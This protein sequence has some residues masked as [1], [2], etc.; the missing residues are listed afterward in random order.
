LFARGDARTAIAYGTH[1]V[2]AVETNLEYVVIG[3]GT[4]VAH[5]EDLVP[6]VDADSPTAR[7]GQRAAEA[8]VRYE[9]KA[10]RGNI[11]LAIGAGVILTGVAISVASGA[12]RDSPGDSSPG[13][14]IGKALFVGGVVGTIGAGFWVL[15]DVR[16]AK[17]ELDDERQSAFETYNDDL[18]KHL[19]VCADGTRIVA[20]AP[21]APAVA[22]PI[23]PAQAPS[24][25]APAFAQ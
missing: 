1:G 6:L 20:C 16:A 21:A 18:R 10:R 2:A 19:R 17:R 4:R 7:A 12:M 8:R 24:P 13:D 14:T 3:D 15:S 25:P 9:R 11:I 5:P 22:P 23:A